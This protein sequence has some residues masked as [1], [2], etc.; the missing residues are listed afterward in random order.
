MIYVGDKKVQK[1]FLGDE[2]IGKVYQGNDLLYYN[3]PRLP[4]GYKEVEYIESNGTQYIDTGVLNFSGLNIKSVIALIDT[5][6]E[7]SQ[8]EFTASYKYSSSVFYFIGFYH[9]KD[10]IH[11]LFGNKIEKI[12]ESTGGVKHTYGI[13][14]DKKEFWFDNNKITTGTSFR[15]SLNSMFIFANHNAYSNGPTGFCNMKLYS[16][17]ITKET[18]GSYIRQFVPCIN[19]SGEA[20]LYDLADRKFYSNSGTGAFVAG[21]AV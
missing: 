20:G 17:D 8:Y 4:I 3:I 9:N 1:C 12:G 11:C 14:I 10:G 5:A 15:T 6:P 19:S 18:D 13:F 21:P 7:Y 16:F 2:R